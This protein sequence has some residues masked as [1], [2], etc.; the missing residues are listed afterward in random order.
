MEP[1]ASVSVVVDRKIPAPARDQQAKPQPFISSA[2]A[3]FRKAYT[4]YVK[5]ASLSLCL[6]VYPHRTTRHPWTK[7]HEILYFS[8]FRKFVEKIKSL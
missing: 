3:K 5:S 6:S 1:T 4:S 7:F 2:F 8:I